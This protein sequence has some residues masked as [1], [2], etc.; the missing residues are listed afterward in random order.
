M[1]TP[2]P[3][4]PSAFEREVKRLRLKPEQYAASAKLRDWCL[5]N[6]RLHFVPEELLKA[7]RSKAAPGNN[8]DMELE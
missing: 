4:R 7:W 1:P 5:R 8:E 2:E 3:G 6:M